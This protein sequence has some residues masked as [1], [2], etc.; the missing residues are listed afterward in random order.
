LKEGDEGH[1]S[2]VISLDLQQHH[3]KIAISNQFPSLRQ[4]F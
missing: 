4:T 1:V 3:P 2:I